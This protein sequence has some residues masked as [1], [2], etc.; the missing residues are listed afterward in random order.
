M[1]GLVTGL[2]SV[3]VDGLATG[4]NTAALVNEL[5]SAASGA[6]NQAQKKLN[7]YE[8]L[9]SLYTTLNTKVKAIDTALAA[10]KDEDD[11]REFSGTS[12]DDDV[13]TLQ[14]MA[15]LWLDPMRLQ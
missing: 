11:F 9:S 15:M 8:Q 5:V 1:S 14:R 10:I 12:S 4:L 3:S 7:N 2:G 6:K 13:F